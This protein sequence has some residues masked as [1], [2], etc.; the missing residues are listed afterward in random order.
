ML[1]LSDLSDYM[2][3]KPPE[4]VNQIP[5]LLLLNINLRQVHTKSG[6]FEICVEG[7]N[8]DL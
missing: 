1:L 2:L 3:S 6:K 7:Q 4:R 8:E 5:D